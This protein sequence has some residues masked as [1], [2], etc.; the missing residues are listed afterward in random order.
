MNCNNYPENNCNNVLYQ[1]G[2]TPLSFSLENADG[3]PFDLSQAT[4]IQVLLPTLV[5]PPVILTLTGLAV[6]L[7]SGGGGGQFSCLVSSSKASL[8]K[9]G[10]ID[11][12][13]RA[14]IAGK[15]IAAEIF[16]QLFVTP[17]LFPGY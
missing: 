9:L 1:S 17:S 3:S 10:L 8:L 16:G 14:T 5:N 4:E 2:D 11:V 12:E 6:T 13:V 7:V 15:I